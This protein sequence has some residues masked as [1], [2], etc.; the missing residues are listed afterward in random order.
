M[1]AGELVA[2][3]KK[4]RRLTA[5]TAVAAVVASVALTACATA[6]DAV[7]PP[8]PGTS[9]TGTGSGGKTSVESEHPELRDGPA[10]AADGVLPDRASPFDKSL[11]GISKLDPALLRAVQRAAKAMA[12]DGITLHVNTGWRS[13]TYQEQLLKKAIRKYGSEEE[14]RKFVATP[15]ESKHVT[16]DA[17]DLGPTAADDWLIRR[18]ARFGLCQT[19]ANERWHFELKTEPGGKCPPPV[20]DARG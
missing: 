5:L 7:P 19:L 13:T 6:T 16:G 15:E 20:A 12:M 10:T 14:A 9:S 2:T 8:G 17:V 3:H 4:K 11:P 18:G 1:T